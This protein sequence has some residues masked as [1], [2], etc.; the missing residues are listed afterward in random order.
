MILIQSPRP[1]ETRHSFLQF[2]RKFTVAYFKGYAYS[3]QIKWRLGIDECFKMKMTNMFVLL[4]YIYYMNSSSFSSLSHRLVLSEKNISNGFLKKIFYLII[5]NDLQLQ[6]Y[7]HF[8]THGVC[9]CYRSSKN[10]IM[11]GWWRTLVRYFCNTTKNLSINSVAF[12]VMLM[13]YKIQV[14]NM[15]R[16]LPL[17]TVKTTSDG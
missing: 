12:V 16:R 11:K 2:V 6:D 13:A 17:T 1:R 14:K 15:T 3:T 8:T 4:D 9:S 5:S 10:H 7:T